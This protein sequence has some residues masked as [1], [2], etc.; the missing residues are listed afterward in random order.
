MFSKFQQQAASPLLQ[1]PGREHEREGTWNPLRY[2]AGQGCT[3]S[4][5]SLFCFL[6]RSGNFSSD[7]VN[8]N[9]LTRL[10]SWPISI[11]ATVPSDI[12]EEMV[13]IVMTAVD[14][15]HWDTQEIPNYLKKELDTRFGCSWHVVVGEEF[16]FDVDVE[17][18][19]S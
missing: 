9:T 3:S 17:V 18:R 8:P 16:G 12:R 7:I 14:K 6:L 1:Q 5:I 4:S 11:R 19:Q 13:E 15:F 10:T 2:Q